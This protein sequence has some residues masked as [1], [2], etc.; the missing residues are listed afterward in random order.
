MIV[1]ITLPAWIAPQQRFYRVVQ[2][3]SQTGRAFVGPWQAS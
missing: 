1:R 3:L 2:E